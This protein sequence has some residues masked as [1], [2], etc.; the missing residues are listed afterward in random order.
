MLAQKKHP[1]ARRAGPSGAAGFT[2][3]EIMIAVTIFTIV[4]TGIFSVFSTGMRAYEVG[5]R[6]SKQLQ[7]GRFAMDIFARDLKNVY[8]IN[9]TG[10]N[11]QY[12]KRLRSID[13]QVKKV[14][15][16]LA[17][18]DA[19]AEQ[20]EQFN[21]TGFGIDLAFRASGN[22]E[23]SEMS[24]VRRQMTVGSSRP[25]QPFHYVRVRYAVSGGQL[26]R[27]EEDILRPDLDYD[28]LEIP[29]PDPHPEILVRGVK[30]FQLRFGFYYDGEWRETNC[31]DSKSKQY[32]SDTV[33]LDFDP[34]D[35][36]DQQLQNHVRQWEQAQPDDNLPSYVRVTL[37][38]GDEDEKT[39]PRRF[40]RTINLVG[41]YESHVPMPEELILRDRNQREVS[42][43]R[44]EIVSPP[45]EA[46]WRSTRFALEGQN[47]RPR[48]GE[49]ARGFILDRSTN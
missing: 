34:D 47:E 11:I 5:M 17:D 25:Y 41:A 6:A 49:A 1:T 10:Y 40:E 13:N 44:E 21:R 29:R 35:M 7:T 43:L 28:G 45:R 15:L 27:G 23:F 36:L 31:W 22:G 19:V 8:F 38:V 2:L 20:I 3:L 16:G 32:R 39:L 9:E 33:D 26:I 18:L 42:I 12:T 30:T 4:T 24:F 37:V 46:S 48:R 14:E